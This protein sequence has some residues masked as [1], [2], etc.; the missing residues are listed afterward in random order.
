MIGIK[1]VNINSK[2]DYLRFLSGHSNLLSELMGAFFK[3]IDENTTVVFD[4]L[5]PDEYIDYSVFDFLINGIG[6]KC[7]KIQVE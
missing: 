7:N 3:D 6:L 4:D 5:I 2:L 1:T